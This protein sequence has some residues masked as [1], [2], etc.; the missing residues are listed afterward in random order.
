[1]EAAV[2]GEGALRDVT[3][4]K[5]LR[6]RLER[7]GQNDNIRNDE[8]NRGNVTLYRTFIILNRSTRLISFKALKL[9]I[10][11]R[12]TTKPNEESFLY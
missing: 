9:G 1:M 12:C 7:W 8:Q 11:D 6:G 3:T 10:P 4:Q 2:S 5:R